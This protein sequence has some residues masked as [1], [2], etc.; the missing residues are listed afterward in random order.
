[1][2]T[3]AKTIFSSIN[4]ISDIVDVMVRGIE[5]EWVE[6][7]MDTFGDWRFE[8]WMG[9][10]YKKVCIGCAATNTLCELMQEP[11]SLKNIQEVEKRTEKVNYGISEYDLQTFELSIDALRRGH[12]HGFCKNLHYIAHLFNFNKRDVARLENFWSTN[13]IDLPP[14]H[15]STYKRRISYYKSFANELRKINL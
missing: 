3:K 4:K 15:T 8:K 6:I 13:D 14:L 9:I 2:T 11:F 10:P 12:V 1:M 5:R 7:N